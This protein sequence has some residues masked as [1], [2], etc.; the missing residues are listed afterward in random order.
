[1]RPVDHDL[2]PFPVNPVKRSP[3]L[4]VRRFGGSGRSTIIVLYIEEMIQS[5]SMVT[6]TPTANEAQRGSTVGKLG[7][8]L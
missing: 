8:L 1:M 7:N 4:T 2:A 6:K 3:T 5:E